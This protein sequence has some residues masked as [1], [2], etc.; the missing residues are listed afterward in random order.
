M[1]MSYK[2][3][4]FTLIPTTSDLKSQATLGF[5]HW[6]NYLRIDECVFSQH[7]PP[8]SCLSFS[9][10]L[11]QAL[12]Y[13]KYTA[14][15]HLFTLCVCL[16]DQSYPTLCDLMDYSPPSSSVH[17]IFQARIL[18]W[19]A[20]SFSRGSSWPRDQTH[21]PCVSCTDRQILY[22]CATRE[23]LTLTSPYSKSA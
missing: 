4:C 22:H 13:T 19:V 20:I 14:W 11:G 23:A 3:F 16:C 9:L 12:N 1:K 7:L 17:G 18:E 2:I 15:I 8:G 5:H 10:S 21:I 6:L